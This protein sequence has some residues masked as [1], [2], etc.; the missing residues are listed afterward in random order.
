MR[1]RDTWVLI[2][3]ILFIISLACVLIALGPAKGPGTLYIYEFGGSR[4]VVVKSAT[5]WSSN[6]VSY[7]DEDGVKH[8]TSAPVHYVPRGDER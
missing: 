6:G 8:T 4:A 2:F 5:F 1:I 3:F 7:T